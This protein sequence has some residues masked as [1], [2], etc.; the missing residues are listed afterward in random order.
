MNTKHLQ[1]NS[2]TDIT[3]AGELLRSG[4]VVGIP[5]ETVYGLAANALDPTAVKKIFIAKGRPSD[6]PLIVHIAELSQWAQLV[7]E[8]PESAQKLAQ[9]YWPGPLTIIL[10]KSDL[11]PMETSGGL[12]TVGVRF[13]SHP[14]AQAVIRAAGVPLAA[15]SANLSGKPSPTTFAHLCEDMDGRVAA[16]VDGGDCGVGVESTVL[17]LVGD[18]PRLLRP[19]GV[20]LAQLESILGEVDVDPAVLHQLKEGAVV[21]SPGMKYR[22]YAPKAT[23]KLV[24]GSPERYANFVNAALQNHESGY[25]LCFDEDLPFLT[26]KTLSYGSRFDSQTQ[27]HRLFT[28]LHELDGMGAALVYAHAPKKS[29]VGLAVYNRMVRAAGFCI[30]KPQAP[31]LIGLTGQSAAGKSTVAE[32]LREHGCAIIDCD[33]LTRSGEVYNTECIGELCTVFGD[34][35]APNGVLDRK[36]LAAR[37]FADEPSKA[38][39]HEIVFPHILAAVE[40]EIARHTRNGAEKIVLDA[41]TLFEAGLDSRCDRIIAVTA[42]YEVRLRRAMQRDGITEEQAKL[43][44]AV[45]KTEEFFLTHADHTIENTA[46]ESLQKKLAPVLTDLDELTA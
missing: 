31:V 17:S 25:A 36:L 32:L 40:R 20:T 45:Q 8:I 42:P 15:P 5:T 38:K 23:V 37:A 12:S 3:L 30:E 9:A 16:L 27:A 18:R 29:G 14:A 39:L 4:E 22:H 43:R 34:E 6:N 41:P 24:E 10:E 13:P 1:Q 2:P 33:K 26:T 11:I 28:A 35:L 7:R 21:S 46:R 44:F 19:G